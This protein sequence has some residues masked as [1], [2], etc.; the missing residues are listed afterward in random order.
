MEVQQVPIQPGTT[1]N[2]AYTL[3]CSETGRG[4]VVDPA[5]EAEKLLDVIRENGLDV[6]YIL[7]T[8][9]H[10]D[11]VNANGALR[12]ETGA[13]VMNHPVDG[14]NRDQSLSH[15]M[16]ISCGSLQIMVLHTPGHS[17]GSCCFYVNKRV[18]LTGD[19]LFVG[20]VGGTEG[21]HR[22]AARQYE[23]LHNYLVHLPDDTEVYPGHDYGPRP[24][25]TMGWEK[26]YNPFLRQDNFIEYTRLKD[27]WDRRRDTWERKWEEVLSR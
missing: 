4:I 27:Q 1:R 6:D 11:H 22:S 15:G 26:Q 7:N 25:S 14:V 21:P 24:T 3:K 17:P 16:E 12:K 19:T 23:S 20:K 13:T 2:F 18:L 10:R 9:G 8:H 5:F